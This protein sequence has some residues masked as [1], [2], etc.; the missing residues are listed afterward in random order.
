[1][2][3]R[4]QE[5]FVVQMSWLM[6]EEPRGRTGQSNEDDGEQELRIMTEASQRG[7]EYRCHTD[8]YRHDKTKF[9]VNS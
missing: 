7:T 6:F 2:R 4:K 8:I 1:M 9:E 5:S 3:R